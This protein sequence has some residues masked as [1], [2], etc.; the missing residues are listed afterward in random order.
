M[1]SQSVS[2]K[3]APKTIFCDIDGTLVK[4]A[5]P[6]IA[7]RP[8]YVMEVLSGTIDKLIDWDRKGY[9]IILTTGR[10][11]SLRKVTEVQLSKA[12]IFYDKLIMG[13]GGGQR[14]LINDLKPGRK[15]DTAISINIKRNS[16][17]GELD[18]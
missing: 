10:R 12:G 4:H 16:S 18:I 3:H 2:S 5:P 9:N 6:H 17:I 8:D 11:E 13:I 15:Y 7:S 14:Y 1:D